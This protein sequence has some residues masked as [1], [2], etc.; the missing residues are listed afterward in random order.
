MKGIKQTPRERIQ[1]RKGHS[2]CTAKRSLNVF[3]A[4]VRSSMQAQNQRVQN[5]KHYIKIAGICWH[6]STNNI[7]M[8]Y[9]KNMENGKR[10]TVAQCEVV[11]C[12][13]GW[14]EHIESSPLT[15]DVNWLSYWSEREAENEPTE[16][17]CPKQR[18]QSIS[19]KASVLFP[20]DPR[21]C[22]SSIVA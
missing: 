3:D 17:T 6:K 14:L 20:F 7:V 12:W 10:Y 11:A 22:E 15:K 2:Q 4:I 18:F 21:S 5:R 13:F 1:L 8:F 9:E 19:S 16:T